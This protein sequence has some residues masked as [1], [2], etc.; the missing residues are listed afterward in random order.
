MH[1]L[2][3]RASLC[4]NYLRVFLHSDLSTQNAW[5]Q[6]LANYVYKEKEVILNSI[7]W[8]LNVA[9]S[10]VEDKSL[11]NFLALAY[12]K[13]FIVI[14]SIYPLILLFDFKLVVG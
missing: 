4:Y 10:I 9:G 11:V 2:F 5:L 13:F 12:S 8:F 7:F 6:V 1:V 3:C 14:L